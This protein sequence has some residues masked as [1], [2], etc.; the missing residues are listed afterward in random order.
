MIYHKREHMYCDITLPWAVVTMRLS[1]HRDANSVL[2]SWA[3][4]ALND[5]AVRGEI[6]R[7]AFCAGWAITKIKRT[8]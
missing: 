6:K 2:E 8:K 1:V 4:A 3:D 5:L 7:G